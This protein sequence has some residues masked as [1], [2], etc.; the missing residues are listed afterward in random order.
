MDEFIDKLK[1]ILS[2][3]VKERY[4]KNNEIEHTTTLQNDLS[5]LFN[6]NNDIVRRLNTLYNKQIHSSKQT[7]TVTQTSNT[8]TLKEFNK[9]KNIFIL[10]L[11]NTRNSIY[12]RINDDIISFYENI[13]NIEL[14]NNVKSNNIN[15]E[16]E[17]D[18]VP[19]LLEALNIKKLFKECLS[20]LDDTE[21]IINQPYY[22]VVQGKG[23]YISTKKISD[24]EIYYKLCNILDFL[25]ILIKIKKFNFYKFNK[26]LLEA[27]LRDYPLYKLLNYYDSNKRVRQ[28]LEINL[29]I[30]S[31]KIPYIEKSKLNYGDISNNILENGAVMTHLKDKIRL[32]ETKGTSN[33]ITKKNIYEKVI[34]YIKGKKKNAMLYY[35]ELLK[36]IRTYKDTELK[37]RKMAEDN[38][39]QDGNCKKIGTQREKLT[40]LAVTST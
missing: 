34:K 33:Y 17:G 20:V 36:V 25:N 26:F 24:D 35:L 19:N 14:M 38:F 12:S 32:F 40:A 16:I 30:I 9:Q 27:E 21:R 3:I 2:N 29:K 7:S 15:T 22:Y 28:D 39:I 10:L 31:S 37:Y 13:D 8:S 5:G 18:N 11:Q 23:K 6:L 1:I 4:T